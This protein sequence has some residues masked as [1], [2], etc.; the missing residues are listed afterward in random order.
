MKTVALSVVQAKPN[1]DWIDCLLHG[2]GGYMTIKLLRSNVDE[3]IYRNRTF[4]L[5]EGIDTDRIYEGEGT[6]QVVQE[7]LI[8]MI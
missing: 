3:Y 6:A 2:T 4:Y 1:G 8:H 5:E 7:F